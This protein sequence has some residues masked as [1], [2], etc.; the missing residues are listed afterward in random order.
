MISPVVQKLKPQ[1]L[2]LPK[3]ASQLATNSKKSEV[4]TQEINWNL[5]DWSLT[6]LNSSFN[7]YYINEP[8]KFFVIRPFPNTLKGYYYLKI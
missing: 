6:L 8:G 1:N 2:A 5:V 3:P 7:A 4:K